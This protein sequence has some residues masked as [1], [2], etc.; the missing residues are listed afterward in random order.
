[1]SISSPESSASYSYT[2]T[3]DTCDCNPFP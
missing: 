3:C 2:V 1:V